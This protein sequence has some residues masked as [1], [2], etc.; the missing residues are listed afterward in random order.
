MNMWKR[1]FLTT[2]ILLLVTVAIVPVASAKSFP[3]KSIDDVMKSWS[4]KFS[5]Q[6]DKSSVTEATVYI[7]QDSKKH[8]ASVELLSDGVTVK[9]TPRIPYVAEKVYQLEISDKI[10]SIK[11]DYLSSKTTKS[12][13]VTDSSTAIQKIQYHSGAGV[14]E[15]KITTKPEVHSVKINGVALGLTGWNEFTYASNNLKAGSTVTIRAYSEANRI[16]DTR[17]YKV[18]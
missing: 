1:F 7:M 17:T 2:L 15:F 13:E 4:I 6:V 16:L 10:R 3:S 12:F 18:D 9:I 5:Q 11:G 14:H 8:A